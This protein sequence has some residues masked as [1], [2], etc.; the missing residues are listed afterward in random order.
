MII[1]DIRMPGIDGYELTRTIKSD[2]HTA[3]IPVILITGL[4]DPGV[5]LEGIKAGCDDFISKP[6]DI[7]ELRARVRSFLKLSI[8]EKK[9]E[10][11]TQLDFIVDKIS[12]GIVIC[13][14]KFNI[15]RINQ[16]AAEWLHLEEN[17]GGNLLDQLYR[18]FKSK[19]S[20]EKFLSHTVLNQSIE[21][22]RDETEDAGVFYLHC[23]VSY[24][25]SDEALRNVIFILKDVTRERLGQR[26]KQDFVSLVSH[27]LRTP[28]VAIT[29][30]A[31]ILRKM[32]E[33]ENNEKAEEIFEELNKNVLKLE[34]LV[35]KLINFSLFSNSNLLERQKKS[36]DPY[37][38]LREAVKKKIYYYS[39]KSVE[40]TY[41][42]ELPED[43]AYHRLTRSQFAFLMENLV[44]N[45]IKFNDNKSV[46]IEFRL[47]TESNA[48]YLTITDNGIGIPPEEYERI[49]EPFYQYEKI[50]TGNVEGM[51]IGLALIRRMLEEIG[52]KIT[53]RS[54]LSEGT[55]FT[56]ELP[57]YSGDKR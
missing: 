28:L 34:S 22:Y 11:E 44:E 31:G 4:D 48:L 33:A 18:H 42:S 13:D 27:K 37:A 19:V 57:F 54:K 38:V 15:T 35:D 9:A 51:G 52:G 30:M 55:T 39:H 32:I 56:L 50:F 47:W 41:R 21:F 53:V 6:Y 43:F 46:N 3:R 25:W 1:S 24:I 20:K 5:K 14:G 26:L 12:N 40:V 8:Y 10:E 2:P 16:Q 45:A 36:F 23:D 49:F 29:G 17:S 7:N